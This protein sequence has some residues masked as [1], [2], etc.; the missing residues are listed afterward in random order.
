[1]LVLLVL[2]FILFLAYLFGRLLFVIISY[3]IDF[4]YCNNEYIF[5]EKLFFIFWS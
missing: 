1:M 5:Y 4:T 3:F 2:L